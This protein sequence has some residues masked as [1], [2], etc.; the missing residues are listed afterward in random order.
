[1][2]ALYIVTVYVII[3][4]TL[5]LMGHQDDTR[6][7]ITTAEILTVAVVAAKYFQNHHERALAILQLTHYLPAFSLS[8]FN[9]RLHHSQAYLT[10]LVTWLGEQTAQMGLCVMDALPLP[11]C[12]KVR[13]DR[14]RKVR[15][16]GF[17]GWSSAKREWYFGW[18]LHWLCDTVG[19]PITF[20]LLPAAWHELTAFHD[21]TADLPPGT[22]VV[23][24]GAYISH[25][26]EHMA[27]DAGRIGLI[28]K[29]HRRMKY[30]NSAEEL[31]CLTRYLPVIETAHSQLDKMGITRLHARTQAGFSLK[32]A[33]S[34]LALVFNH[35]L[36]D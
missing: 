11:V 2:N 15:G 27:W 17:M 6:S 7:R 22:L 32:V 20:T 25:T 14:C 3:A 19:V 13:A 16:R 26:D 36:P 24:D 18:R 23:A 28:P 31:A 9:R 10:D 4:D 12:K 29:R 8:R 21:L 34:L 5:L 1:M 33:A 30:P 35:L